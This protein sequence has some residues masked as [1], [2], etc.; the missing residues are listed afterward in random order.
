M[1]EKIRLKNFRCFED[2]TIEFDKFN[3]IVGK[4]NS[5]KS[6]IIDALKL[7]SNVVRYAPYRNRDLEDRDIPFSTIN[8]K[9]NYNKEESSIFAKFTDAT[10]I[11]VIFPVDGRPYAD[12]LKNGKTNKDKLSR[13][14]ILGIIPS[15]GTF[16]EMEKIGERDYVRSKMISHLTPR[17][18]RG[19]W[20]QN[21][22]GFEEFRKL[23]ERT[24]PGYSIDFPEIHFTEDHINLYIDMYYTEDRISRE[25]F[26]AGH[27]FQIWL[28]LMTFLVKLGPKETLVLDEPDIYLHQDLQRKLVNI[29]KERANQVIIATHAVDIIEEVEPED[30]IS[31]DKT[32]NIS[33][34]LSTIDEVQICINQLGS[35]QNLKLVNFIRGKTCLFVEG[36]DF[37]SLKKYA[38]KL[39][40]YQF[41]QEDG[42]SVV[43]LE[44]FSNWERLLH[45]D[46][47]FKNAFG[48]KVKCFVILDRDYYSDQY[49]N[50]FIQNLNGK[51]VN[52]HIWSKKELENFLIN[53][54]LLFRIF[55][56]E[57]QKRYPDREIPLSSKEFESELI[58][59]FDPFKIYVQGQMISKNIEVRMDKRIKINKSL[60]ASVI[61][62]QTLEEFE[63]KWPDI[64]YRKKVI[65]G[66]DYFSNMNQWLTEK[67]KLSI[68]LSNINKSLLKDEIDIEIVDAINDFMRL[69]K[70]TT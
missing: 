3:V 44:G 49:I 37:N 69:V 7:I 59:L 68:S 55:S 52:I 70:S 56:S 34:R 21:P 5:G 38:K 17:H 54:K 50:Y 48:E 60:D 14:K 63:R 12:L 67:Y 31:I 40:I 66:K 26:W 42:F 2:F 46:W 51:G 30:I 57:Y 23:V 19:I 4:N 20:Y 13:E 62:T 1:L 58:S 47:L 15:V 43:P 45:T 61:T 53:F 41:A 16:E 36:K 24:W 9:Y 65:P 29:C 33:K 35:Y 64:E 6:T 27:G 39:D 10:E 32:L 25:I 8:L 18:F 28:Q 11:E 22:E